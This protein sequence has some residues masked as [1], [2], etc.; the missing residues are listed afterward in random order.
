MQARSLPA[1]HGALWLLAGF[2]LFRRNPP[3][4]TALTL[5]YLFLIVV[6]NL[7][8][9]VGPFLLP[10]ALP[11]LAV[12]VANGCRAIEDGKMADADALTRGLRERRVALVRLGGLHLVGSM[13][14]LAINLLVEGGDSPLNAIEQA[15]EQAVLGAMLRLLVVATPVLMAFWFAPLLAAWDA[16][17]PGKSVFFS[18]VASLRNW[19][20]FLAYAVTVALVAVALPGLLMIAAG[21][22]SKTLLDVLSVALRMLLV[23]VVAPTLAA[24][25]YVSY[26]DVF[27]SGTDEA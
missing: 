26:R 21:A 7:L 2:R 3:L 12:L 15:D 8:P 9:L 22:V 13:L 23:F 16:V 14:I 25:V 1:R 20:A 18:F 19:R 27:H 11:T 17:S 10:L 5:G 6:I 24:S 4:L